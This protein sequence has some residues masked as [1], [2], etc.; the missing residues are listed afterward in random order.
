MD[1][2]QVLLDEG[3]VNFLHIPF[4]ISLWHLIYT[5]NWCHAVQSFLEHSENTFLFFFI[6]SETS[7]S[8]LNME[9]LLHNFAYLFYISHLMYGKSLLL[10][11]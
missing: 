1:A 9:N 5:Y 3:E 8:H 7:R 10:P 11:K 4:F 2:A 6:S